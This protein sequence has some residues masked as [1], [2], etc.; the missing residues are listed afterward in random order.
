MRRLLVSLKVFAFW[1]VMFSFVVLLL[2]GGFKFIWTTAFSKQGTLSSLCQYF[3]CSWVLYPIL[4]AIDYISS[5]LS[6]RDYLA[7]SL[8]HNLETP[9]SGLSFPRLYRS[10]KADMPIAAKV[11]DFFVYVQ[12]AMEMVLWWFIVL[13]SVYNLINAHDVLPSTDILQLSNSQIVLRISSILVVYLVATVMVRFFQRATQKAWQ[14]EDRH[15]ARRLAKA[16][17]YD[18]HPTRIP[19]G[20]RAC[21]GP[22]PNCRSSCQIYND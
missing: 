1:G 9:Y 17:Y 14:A 22:Y 21:G 2:N 12:R 10:I 19:S 5:R 15:S 11:S 18:R 16:D 8:P 13:T 6:V 3:C 4:V 7:I 20:C